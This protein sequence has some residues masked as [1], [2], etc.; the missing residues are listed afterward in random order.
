MA[1][2]VVKDGEVEQ[3]APN[4]VAAGLRLGEHPA[5]GE[6]PGTAVEGRKVSPVIENETRVGLASTAAQ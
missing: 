4:D 6:R 2:I 1:V 3:S 5:D